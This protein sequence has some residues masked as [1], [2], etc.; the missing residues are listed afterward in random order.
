MT[1]VL[2]A[3]E[4]GIYPTDSSA[5]EPTLEIQSH[6]ENSD[7]PGKRGEI[8]PD[9]TPALSLAQAGENPQSAST[10]VDPQ[11]LPIEDRIDYYRSA[12]EKLASAESFREEVLYQVYAHLL[13]KS[14]REHAA[15]T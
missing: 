5:R 13:E 1:A 7:K 12:I 8:R 11:S 4:G 9:T 3:H 2:I 6:N 14:L 10:T 15:V